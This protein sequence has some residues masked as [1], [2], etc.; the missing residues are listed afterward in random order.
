MAAPG[1]K[2]TANVT[3]TCPPQRSLRSTVAKE[4]SWLATL[5]TCN[6]YNAALGASGDSGC[7][8]A[9]PQCPPTRRHCSSARASKLQH[10]STCAVFGGAAEPGALWQ[11]SGRHAAVL[12]ALFEVRLC[13]AVLHHR[14]RLRCNEAWACG[15]GRKGHGPSHPDK[16]G[17]APELAQGRALVQVVNLFCAGAPCGASGL[18]YA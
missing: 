14:T 3:P 2:L 4:C 10:G 6:D 1:W 7:D 18:A 17:S 12:V 9:T 13:P 16:E 15:A 11:V 8:H 5:Q